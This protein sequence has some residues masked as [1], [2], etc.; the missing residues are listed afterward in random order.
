MSFHSDRPIGSENDF[1]PGVNVELTK[2][3]RSLF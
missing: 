2:T 3:G 1:P